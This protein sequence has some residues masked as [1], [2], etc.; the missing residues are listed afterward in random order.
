MPP[1]P[2]TQECASFLGSDWRCSAGDGFPM[3]LGR[4][5]PE[6]LREMGSV[7]KAGGMCNEL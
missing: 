6:S 4:R 5:G 7:G 1:T 3:L 2:A